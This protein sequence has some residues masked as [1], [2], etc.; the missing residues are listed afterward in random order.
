MR[1]STGRFLSASTGGGC[2]IYFRLREHASQVLSTAHQHSAAPAQ[3]RGALP[4]KP[5]GPAA[6]A[7][8]IPVAQPAAQW[9]LQGGEQQVELA[10][11]LSRQL[12]AVKCWRLP[13]A[14]HNLPIKFMSPIPLSTNS[15]SGPQLSATAPPAAVAAATGATAPCVAGSGT[16]AGHA[17]NAATR[18]GSVCSRPVRGGK[19]QRV[20]IEPKPHAAQ[21]ALG[22][23]VQQACERKDATRAVGAGGDTTCSAPTCDKPPH[24]CQTLHTKAPR[25]AHTHT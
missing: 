19:I 16:G 21:H 1:S 20:E 15:G 9:C 23:R 3:G 18:W 5:P 10:G 17:L 25:L 2:A 13:R 11:Q 6:A 12:L 7:A 22:R 4:A 14:T 8:A 24:A